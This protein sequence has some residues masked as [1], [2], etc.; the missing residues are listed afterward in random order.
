MRGEKEEVI[1]GIVEPIA[2]IIFGTMLVQARTERLLKN[3]IKIPLN[4][5]QASFICP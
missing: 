3:N 4:Q 1:G 5:R 2:L